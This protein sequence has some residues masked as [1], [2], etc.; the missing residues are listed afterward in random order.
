MTLTITMIKMFY[1]ICGGNFKK[2]I[3]V[4]KKK[5]AFHQCFFFFLQ[6]V[7]LYIDSVWDQKCNEKKNWKIYAIAVTNW[8]REIL[9]ILDFEN[10]SNNLSLLGVYTHMSYCF[11]FEIRARYDSIW[12]NTDIGF[13]SPKTFDM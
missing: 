4:N 10:F 8:K 7:L 1:R 2:Y 9:R 11:V 13:F 12:C 6:A 3:K 5:Y